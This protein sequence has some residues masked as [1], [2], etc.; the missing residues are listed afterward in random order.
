MNQLCPKAASSPS[1]PLSPVTFPAQSDVPLIEENQLSFAAA[2]RSLTFYLLQ[3]TDHTVSSLILHDDAHQEVAELPLGQAGSI[4]LCPA[5]DQK[6][7]AM[8]GSPSW[9]PHA[10]AGASG[11]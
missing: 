5:R 1:C 7:K 4:P 9:Y 2:A 8:N 11:Q 6:G 3:L 10:Q